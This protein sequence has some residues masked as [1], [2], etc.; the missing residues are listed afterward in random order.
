MEYNIL[1]TSKPGDGLLYYSYEYCCYM[2]SIGIDTQLV[3]IPHPGFNRHHYDNVIKSKYTIYE[4]VTYDCDNWSD[5]TIVMGRSL[6][7]IGYISRHLYTNEQLEL[8]RLLL[9]GTVVS[10]YSDNRI[11]EYALAAAWASPKKIIDVCDRDVYPNG[12]GN[13]FEKRIYFDIYRPVV[14]DVK[15]KY[16]FNGTNKQYYADALKVIDK[17]ESHGIL[18]YDFSNVDNH[19]NNLYIPVDNLLGI[20]DTYVYTKS[21]ID[22][23]PRIIQE[24]KYYNKEIIL[25]QYNRGVGFYLTR[26]CKQP[27]VSELINVG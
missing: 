10:V 8:L 1:C 21:I 26:E 16:L 13:H 22:P 6:I 14:D 18:V 24:C 2:N 19:Y 12:V 5:V 20:F 11:V 3:I 7:T 27:D 15:F 9:S 17:Y 25:E 4:N 23:A